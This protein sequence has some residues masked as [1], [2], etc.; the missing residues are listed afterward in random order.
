MH[1][2]NISDNYGMNELRNHENCDMN[3]YMNGNYDRNVVCIHDNCD[4]NDMHVRL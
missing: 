4:M 1:V 3:G 2:L